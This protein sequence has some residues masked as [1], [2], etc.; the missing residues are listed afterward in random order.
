MTRSGSLSDYLLQSYGTRREEGK[1]RIDLAEN[2]RDD[3]VVVDRRDAAQMRV[4]INERTFSLDPS[5]FVDFLENYQLGRMDAGDRFE[6]RHQGLSIAA[7]E[8]FD[9][10]AGLFFSWVSR[11]LGFHSEL[12]VKENPIARELDR[13]TAFGDRI[14]KVKD[15]ELS[16][17]LERVALH[18]VNVESASGTIVILPD[19]RLGLVTATHVVFWDKGPYPHVRYVR[20]VRFARREWRVTVSHRGPLL[21]PDQFNT[22]KDVAILTFS[23]EDEAELRSMG[24][25]GIPVTKKEDY[26]ARFQKVFTM[27]YPAMMGRSLCLLGGRIYTLPSS[28]GDQSIHQG[29]SYLA[30]DR[31]TATATIYPLDE[32]S[33]GG[34]FWWN[35]KMLRVEL[36]GVMS[37]L[38]EPPETDAF[39]YHGSQGT[40]FQTGNLAGG[41]LSLWAA[42]DELNIQ[43][44]LKASDR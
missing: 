13:L 44:L 7:S 27:G 3:V 5:K 19:G 35:P 12:D 31:G 22:G 9:S 17:E 2:G 42:V 1:I 30:H 25:T 41:R 43:E 23:T 16:N 6:I 28:G 11:E 15:L 18:T 4:Q 32:N 10:P 33:G 14:R 8:R 40:N 21:T 20:N 37:C 26:P 38:S 29:R 36:I 39:V 34:L 24:F